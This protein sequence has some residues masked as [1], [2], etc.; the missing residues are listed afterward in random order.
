MTRLPWALIGLRLACAPLILMAAVLRW[1]G[2]TLF[3]IAAVALLS[4]VF[5]GMV[6]RRL[7]V[8]T[9]PM[10]Q[11]DSRADTV[12]YLAAGAS[13]MLRFPDIWRHYRI[14]VIVLVVLDL[15][16]MT[17]EWRKF[18]RSAAYHMWS[19]KVWGIA[20]LLGFGEVML[21]G[22]AGPLFL[23]AI[24]TGVVTNIEGAVA[25]LVLREWHHDVPS[26][27]HAMRLERSRLA[28]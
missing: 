12:C 20:M 24:V 4:D 27:W 15:G 16:R 26:L 25:S 17:F 13:L 22:R 23:A 21:T 28:T 18:G 19:A 3:A 2:S 8:D 1:P 7:G 10:R 9:A 5:D 11:L 14:G 6:A